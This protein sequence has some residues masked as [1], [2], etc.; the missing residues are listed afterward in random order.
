MIDVDDGLLS[1]TADPVHV[2]FA[3][4]KMPG[5][6]GGDGTARLGVLRPALIASAEQL[7]DLG[8][9]GLGGRLAVAE[10]LCGDSVDLPGPGEL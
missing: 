10:H 9:D 5:L 4:R 2:A 8:T 6:T 1:A 3:C 7:R